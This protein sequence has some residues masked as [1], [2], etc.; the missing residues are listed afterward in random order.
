MDF[1]SAQ[2]TILMG[3]ADTEINLGQG[4]HFALCTN[5]GLL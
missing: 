1:Q 3:L 2:M 5:A 4:K